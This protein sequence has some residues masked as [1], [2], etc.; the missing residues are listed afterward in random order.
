M[1]TN[2]HTSTNG[3]KRQENMVLHRLDRIDRE[4]HGI[5][6]RLRQIE[7]K[8]WVLQTKAAVFG[9]AA[10]LVPSIIFFMLRNTDL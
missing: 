2:E 1:S 10:G 3:W 7:G 4:L 9:A 8:M 6:K 5:D